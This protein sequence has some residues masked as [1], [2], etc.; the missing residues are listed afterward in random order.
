MTCIDRNLAG[1]TSELLCILVEYLGT[2]ADWDFIFIQEFEK[3]NFDDE[4]GGA[5]TRFE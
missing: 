4:E 5:K 1:C 2:L 3:L